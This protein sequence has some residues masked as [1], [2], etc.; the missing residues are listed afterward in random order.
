[1]AKMKGIDKVMNNLNRAIAKIENQSKAGLIEAVAIIQ[2]EIGHVEPMVPHKTGNLAGSWFS[3]PPEMIDG[4][5]TITFGHEAE[6]AANV[7]ERV[8]EN[9]NWFKK[10][11]GA[12]WLQKALDRNHDEILDVIAENAGRGLKK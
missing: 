9:I 7:H 6:Y 10:G 4:N 12:Q 11:T 1:M 8:G 2:W 5:P 3:G